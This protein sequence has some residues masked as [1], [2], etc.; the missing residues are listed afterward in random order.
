M[1]P[2]KELP[3]GTLNPKT[4]K[5]PYGALRGSRFFPRMVRASGHGAAVDLWAVG[6]GSPAFR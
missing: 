3:W 1:K 6:A 5:Y 4:P 2:Q